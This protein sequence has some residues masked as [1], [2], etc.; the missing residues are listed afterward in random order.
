MAFACAGLINSGSVL[1]QDCRLKLKTSVSLI[2]SGDSRR[3][4]VPV[5][6]QGVPKV[7]LLDTGGAVEEITPKVADELHLPRMMSNIT[8]YDVAAQT[9]SDMVHVEMLLGS[10][11]AP[12]VAMVVGNGLD[13]FSNR[14]DFAGILAP[15]IL[16]AYDVDLDFGTGKLSLFSQDHCPG[17]VIYW[18]TTAVAVVPM[19]SL[20]DGHIVV[21][22]TLDGH[23]VD[24]LL[25]T[26]AWG[27]TLA[28][29]DATQTF[30]LTLGS[31]DTPAAGSFQDGSGR[32]LYRHT[33]ASLAFEGIAVAHPQV[34]IIPDSMRK[35]FETKSEVVTGSNLTG[36]P[37]A[38][39]ATSMLVGMNI[40]RHFHIYIAYKERKV[41]ITPVS[42][43]A[44][45][46][47]PEA[48][49]PH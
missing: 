49:A 37:D 31:A 46:I 21:S 29:R 41:Y 22:V 20:S 6:I 45:A 35:R 28:D 23:P 19:K 8:L 33:F 9:S 36:K 16:Q 3:A 14:P 47:A 39:M 40:L 12:A 5:S 27:T 38:G 24:A 13:G 15:D 25:D 44:A 17:G 34:E 11:K 7:L 30:G 1:A 4:F 42:A 26:G 48:A 18:P 10:L 32:P 43:P 2:M